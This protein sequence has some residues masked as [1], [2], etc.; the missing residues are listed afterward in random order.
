MGRPLRVL[1][2]EGSER[3]AQIDAQALRDGG[4][5]PDWRCVETAEDMRQAL[6]AKEWDLVLCGYTLPSF[7][8]LGALDVLRS[9]GLD[10]P[11]IVISH[12]PGSACDEEAAVEAMRAGAHDYIPKGN[13]ARLVPAVERGLREAAVH[14]E[15]REAQDALRRLNEDLERRI[16]ERTAQLEAANREL[17]VEIDERRRVEGAL[18]AIVDNSLAPIY[19]KDLESRYILV[20]TAMAEAH[21]RA[22]DDLVGKLDVE[23]YPSATA[24]Q[25]RAHDRQVAES[26]LPRDFEEEVSLT[27]RQRTFLSAKFPVRGPDGT[28]YATGGVSIDIS[29][30]KAAEVERS[31]LAAIVESSE[32]AI[33]G[34]TL[35]GTIT[36]WN[37]AAE[38]LYGYR[39][40]EIVGRSLGIIIPPDRPNE[41]AVILSRAR[42]GEGVRHLETTRIARD[43]R[44][45]DVSITVSPIRDASGIVVG[46]ST[47]ARDIGERKRAEAE[48]ERLLARI[49]DERGRLEAVLQQAPVGVVIAEAPS[50]R[51][52][53]GNE[54]AREIW[55]LPSMSAEDVAGYA[56]YRGFHPDGRP[57]APEEWPLARALKGEV[58]TDEEITIQRGDGTSGVTSQNAAP[59]RN[60]DGEI[61]ATV[62]TFL[63]ITARKQ[64]EERLRESEA[65]YRTLLDN[66]PQRV[67]YK[68]QNSAYLAV[69]PAY[70]RDCGVSP[71]EVV[72]KTDFD[73]F[74]PEIAEKYRADDRRIMDAGVGEEYDEPYVTGGE[75]LVV[76]TVKVPV[77]DGG[78][79][80]A[81]ILALFWDVTERV[82]AEAE[83]ERLLEQTREANARL[84]EASIVAR[85]AAEESARRAAELDVILLAVPDGLVVYGARGEVIRANEVAT[86]LTGYPEWTLDLSIPERWAAAGMWIETPAGERLEV[87]AWPPFR[88]LRGEVTHGEVF[89]IHRPGRD[90]IW[91]STSA[92]PIADRDGQGR[93]AIATFSD[94]SALQ[95]LEQERETYIH[96][97]S[98]DLRAPLSIILAQGLIARRA[99]S[100]PEAVVKATDAIILGA[101]RM[102]VMIQ[103]LV[104]SARIQS[105]RVD[106]KRSPVDLAE[107][108][109]E[110]L[111]RLAPTMPT[112]RITL[113][114]PA[115]LPP[116]SADPARLERILTNL[117]SNALKYSD[118]NTPVRIH[119]SR[120]D[121]E[122]VV[123][124]ADEGR[125]IAPEELP[126]LFERFY[127]ARAGKEH[128][129][130]IGLGLYITKGLVEAHGG[131]V[132]VKSEPGKGSTFSF[133]L[134][135]A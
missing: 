70:A 44:R 131:H 55:R 20:N 33:V 62:V 120:R 12:A 122:V 77:R 85:S 50:G 15:R 113:T 52:E 45:L 76:H 23:I 69:N 1:I 11:F 119:M 87:D 56:A 96:T 68:D 13:L 95:A 42:R 16:A 135:L 133:A 24:E 112:D 132:S 103:D 27:D 41:L 80:V 125:G 25:I 6:D 129:T 7:G 97:I 126:H 67:L 83:R 89:A 73:V 105:G 8:A 99:A 18:R 123:D 26:G 90:P 30:R 51:F 92:A 100:R 66:I 3:D 19:L 37:P 109:R 86:S 4:F 5:E 102:N 59:I 130:S 117:I 49:A 48:R 71:D 75:A 9:S 81:G 134:P 34:M 104:D 38:R 21:G 31:R 57:Y 111:S 114:A 36:N 64:A 116:V 47:I 40:S 82:R 110:L 54:R 121:G 94:I 65:K 43:G 127:R 98:H 78:G 17:R 58:V 35:D 28:I 101:K 10:L 39:A 108:T 60:A 22:V 107:Y 72:G 46:T 84:A 74:P 79:A 106:L 128:V 93:G 88:A 91:V 63:D 124:I 2:V 115:D 53:I 118:P 61:I 29:E 14:R 32:D